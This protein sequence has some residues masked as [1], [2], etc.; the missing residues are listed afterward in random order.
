MNI[1]ISAQRRY[2]TVTQKSIQRHPEIG[3]WK[4]K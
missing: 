4:K 3:I 2:A 1:L